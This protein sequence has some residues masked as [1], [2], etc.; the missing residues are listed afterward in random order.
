MTNDVFLIYA[1]KL[2]INNGKEK[3][4]IQKSWKTLM[5][6]CLI[7][8]SVSIPFSHIS[9]KEFTQI[10]CSCP[11]YSFPLTLSLFIFTK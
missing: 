8:L 10:F 9:H 1:F 4:A 11:I 6:S 2:S 5:P 7:S 3:Y